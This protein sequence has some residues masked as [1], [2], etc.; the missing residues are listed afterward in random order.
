MSNNKVEGYTLVNAN[1]KQ[2]KTLDIGVGAADGSIPA[3]LAAQTAAGTAFSAFTTAKSVING[4]EVVQLPAN[5]FVPGK[6]LRLKVAGGISNIIT[7]PGT[8][9]FQMMLGAVIAWTSGTIQLNAAAHTLLPFALEVDL[10]CD[11]VGA[12]TT[13][14]LLGIGSLRGIMFTL[15]AGQ[16]D[17]VNSGAI[18]M[19]PATAPAVGTGFD[20]TAA[21]TLDFFTAFSISAAGNAVQIY[22]YTL[23]EL[24]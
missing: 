4:S 3:V 11:S 8:V 15:T 24:N 2:V 9:S 17:G 22:D 20:S 14:K 21:Q 1:I 18:M 23:E 19:V 7:T 5:Y 12:T 16:V 6:K 10:R 13:A